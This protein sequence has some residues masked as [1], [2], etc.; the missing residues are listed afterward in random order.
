MVFNDTIDETKDWFNAVKAYHENSFKSPVAF[1]NS[2]LAEQFGLSPEDLREF[3]RA[4]Q[5]FETKWQAAASAYIQGKFTT[6]KQFL[7]SGKFLNLGFVPS[8]EHGEVLRFALKFYEGERRYRQNANSNEVTTAGRYGGNMKPMYSTTKA[9]TSHR[10]VGFDQDVFND[11]TAI[12]E[13][14]DL[15]DDQSAESMS[16][17]SG[18]SSIASTQGIHY[19]CSSRKEP[20]Y[21]Q[22]LLEQL[23]ED[24]ANRNPVD[25]MV[26]FAFAI[27]PLVFFAQIRSVMRVL[28]PFDMLWGTKEDDL[29][30]DIEDEWERLRA[31]ALTASDTFQ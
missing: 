22:C 19:I 14:L 7:S 26:F 13:L 8:R 1:L 10:L 11:T 20:S 28:L 16:R 2:V 17:L 30:V 23:G 5:S 9:R 3:R 4:V 24:R 21:V 29:P 15:C 12:L 27:I 6:R 31:N 25:A 18:E